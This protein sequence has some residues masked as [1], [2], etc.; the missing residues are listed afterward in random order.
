MTATATLIG[1]LSAHVVTDGVPPSNPLQPHAIVYGGTERPADLRLSH[2]HKRTVHD[3]QIVCVSNNPAGARLLAEAVTRAVDGAV[4]D[5]HNRWQVTY[6]S[7][8]IEDRDDPSG[9]RWSSTVE[10]TLTIGR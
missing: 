3:W 8:P 2:V 7:P 1:V 6:A 9:W 10:V 5:T 4:Y